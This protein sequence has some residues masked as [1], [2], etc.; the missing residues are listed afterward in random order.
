MRADKRA[1]TSLAKDPMMHYKTGLHQNPPC[2]R[3]LNASPSH[4]PNFAAEF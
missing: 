2:E 1:Q 4:F 3:I